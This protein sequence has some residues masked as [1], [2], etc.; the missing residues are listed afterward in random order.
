MAKKVVLNV[1]DLGG[2]SYH[3]YSDDRTLDINT[4][5]APSF[6]PEKY[7]AKDCSIIDQAI[8]LKREGFKEEAV[9]R[10]LEIGGE[11]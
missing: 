4:W 1:D 7:T 3:I 11:K 10:I 2:G 5:S 8:K 9:F 6:I